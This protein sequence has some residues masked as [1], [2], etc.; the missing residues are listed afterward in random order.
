MLRLQVFTTVPGPDKQFH[1]KTRIPSPTKR[2]KKYTNPRIKISPEDNFPGYPANQFS[3]SV[4]ATFIEVYRHFFFFPVLFSPS[5]LGLVKDLRET[6][7]FLKDM[8]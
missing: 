1:N 7:L 8:E 2:K 3:P 4:K 6:L 5:K